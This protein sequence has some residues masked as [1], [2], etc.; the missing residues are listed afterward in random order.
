M[1]L[2]GFCTACRRIKQVRVSGAGMSRMAMRGVAETPGGPDMAEAISPDFARE[3][4]TLTGRLDTITTQT[5]PL[6]E[7]IGL[8][9]EV[10]SAFVAG[11]GV[12]EVAALAS[13]SGSHG[14]L[15]S[16]DAHARAI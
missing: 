2:P 13:E 11:R 10:F 9:R 3:I 1:R 14:L 12:D 8:A 16:I 4:R 15:D 6:F 5:R 7:R